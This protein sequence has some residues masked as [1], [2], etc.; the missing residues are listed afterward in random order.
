MAMPH[1]EMFGYQVTSTNKGSRVANEF[2][3]R[4]YKAKTL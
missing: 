2:H 3:M 1:H 4:S